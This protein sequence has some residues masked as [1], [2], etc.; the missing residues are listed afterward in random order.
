MHSQDLDMAVKERSI[1]N[2]SIEAGAV[3]HVKRKALRAEANLLVE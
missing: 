3:G 2:G 1:V